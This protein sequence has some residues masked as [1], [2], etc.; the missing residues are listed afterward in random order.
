[1]SATVSKAEVW[2]SNIPGNII[3]KHAAKRLGDVAEFSHSLGGVATGVLDDCLE[4]LPVIF[5]PA[6]VS[7]CSPGIPNALNWLGIRTPET[8]VDEVACT[9]SIGS[10][11][12][13]VL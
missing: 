8:I 5:L 11:G 7:G 13:G 9:S 10:V 12:W 6:S 4:D 2:G 3:L 1:M